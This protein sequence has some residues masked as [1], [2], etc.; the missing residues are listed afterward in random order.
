MRNKNVLI[1]AGPTAVL[2]DRVRVIS[3]IATGETGI[4]LAQRLTN[5][6][7]KVT[8]LLGPAEA[9][10]IDEALPCH[11]TRRK[12][13]RIRLIRFKFFDELKDKIIQELKTKKYDVVIH[14]AAVSDY[15]PLKASRQKI[16]SGIKHLIL[17]LTPTVKIIDLIRKTSPDTF[18]VGFKFEPEADKELLI[19]EAHNLIRRSLLNLT[20]AN[21]MQGKYKAYIVS[22]DTECGPFLNK[23]KMCDNLIKTIAANLI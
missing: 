5:Q 4:L 8:L 14:S 17:K 21:S 9:G 3:N 19:K 6:G 10:D 16:K 18:L 2:I 7:A 23:P 15:R 1:T 12:H 20:V 11:K 22:K 13:K